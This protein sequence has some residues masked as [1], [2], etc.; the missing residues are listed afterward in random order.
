MRLIWLILGLIVFLLG[1]GFALLN[2]TP[3][4]VH[5]YIGEAN[6]P[7]SVTLIGGFVVGG[8]MGLSRVYPRA[9][10]AA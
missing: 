5:Y 6:L 3:V 2:A 1:V 4:I 8:V 7:L 10:G 9:V